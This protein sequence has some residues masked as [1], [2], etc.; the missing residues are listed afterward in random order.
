MHNHAAC[1]V[2]KFSPGLRLDPGLHA[3]MLVP[4]NTL[5]E[6]VNKTDDDS[7]CNQLRPKACPFGNAARDDGG[8]GGSKRQQKEELHQFIAVPS[9]QGFG[10]NKK[11]GAIGDG[12]A[13]DE[14]HHGR[15]R[16]VHQNFDKRVDLV[17]AA[18]GAELQERKT[19][20]HGQ[21]HDAAQEDE[22]G[23]RALF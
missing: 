10:A 22:Q 18:H 21:N 8:N 7:R 15:Y 17:F 2:M 13:H 4:D 19:G 6:G 23:I 9:H 20:V 12:V 3:E 11:A 14:I 1:K 16:E 5:K